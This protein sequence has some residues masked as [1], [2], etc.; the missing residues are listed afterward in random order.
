VIVGGARVLVSTYGNPVLGR[1]TIVILAVIILRLRTITIE[2][3]SLEGRGG[4]RP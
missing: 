2:T 3:L 4:A 1:L